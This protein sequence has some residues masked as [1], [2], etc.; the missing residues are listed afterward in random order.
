MTDDADTDAAA[1]LTYTN[2]VYDGYLADPFAWE[3]EGVYYA[4]GTGGEPPGERPP[5]RVFPLLRSRDFAR[6]EPAG[7]ALVPPDPALGG[8]FWAPEVAFSEGRFYLYYSV[9]RGDKGHQLRVAVSAD[10]LGPY[11]DQETALVDPSACPF[12]IDPHPF[13]DDDGRWYLFYARDFLDGEEH[14]ARHGTALA[15]DRMVDMTRLAGEERTVLRARSDW[16]RFMA[17]RTMYDAVYDWHTLEGPFVR[18]HEDRYYCFFSGG[19]WDSEF[20][21]VDYGVADHVLGPYTDA[22]NETGA[23]VLRTLPG[24]VLGPGHNSIVTGPDGATDYVVY[25]AWDTERRARRMCLD[26]LVWTDDGPRCEGPTWTPQSLPARRRP[27]N[28]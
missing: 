3:H 16:Q 15:V 24:R 12:A 10:P 13:R 9:G 22:G 8:D 1:A 6:W 7:A 4:I 20:Y 17:G 23:R 2:P 5:E 11:H 14:G 27:E 26:R 25:H 21:G 28:R 18:K 19:R